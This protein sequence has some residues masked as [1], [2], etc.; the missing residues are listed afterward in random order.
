[1]RD[2]EREAADI[3]EEPSE[4][5]VDSIGGDPGAPSC[6]GLEGLPAAGWVGGFGNGNG[7]GNG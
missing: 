1:M 6:S 2:L 3:A 4:S 7:N 5:N